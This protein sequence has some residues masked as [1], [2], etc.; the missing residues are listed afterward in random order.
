MPRRHKEH[1]VYPHIIHYR[2][3]DEMLANIKTDIDSNR[4]FGIRNVTD[5]VHAALTER[6]SKENF[7]DSVTRRLDRQKSQMQVIDLRLKRLEEIVIT[8]L[9]Y[10]FIQFPQFDDS[11]KE[12]ARLR[13]NMAFEKFSR[14]LQRKLETNNYTLGEIENSIREGR[15][16][17]APPR[18]EQGEM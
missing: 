14:V 1:S 17:H 11:Q 10:Y 7:W 13:S 5:V 18:G 15:G 8:F 12:Q 3:S 6:Y 4:A 9:Q 16:A 2:A